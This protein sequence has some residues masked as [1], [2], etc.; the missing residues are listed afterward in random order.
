MSSQIK[1]IETF[2]RSELIQIINGK[3]Q[4]LGVTFNAEDKK[5]FFGIYDL[6]STKFRFVGGDISI[7]TQVVAFVKE[8]ATD[9]SA[10]YFLQQNQRKIMAPDTQQLS[11][12]LFFA[13]KE[14]TLDVVVSQLG[15]RTVN[16]EDMRMELFNNK[17]KPLLETAASSVKLVR[18][19][20]ENIVKIIKVGDKVR[21][22]VVCVFCS[23]EKERTVII[24]CN[25][26]ANSTVCYW[27]TSNFKQHLA[28]HTKLKSTDGV[29]LSEKSGAN[30]SFG[31]EDNMTDVEILLM[32]ANQAD[33]KK[34]KKTMHTR[35]ATR[36]LKNPTK[37]K[38]DS[39]Q[40]QMEEDKDDEKKPCHDSR[41]TSDM[42]TLVNQMSAQN[43]KNITSARTHS[44]Q[45]EVMKFRLD[46]NE[47]TV[48]VV[49]IKPNGSC[50]FGSIAHQLYGCQVDSQEHQRKT[51][52]LRDET[53]SYIKSNYERFK[54]NLQGRVY[55][56]SE[57]MYSA[58]D[59]EKE[60]RFF[61][62]VCLPRSVCFAGHESVKAISE[63][64]KINIMTISENGECYMA[65]DFNEE[66]ERTVFLALR[67][68]NCDKASGTTTNAHNSQRNHYD[69][70]SKIDHKVLYALAGNCIKKNVAKQL[71]N[72]SIVSLN[73][74]LG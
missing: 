10:S 20:G 53:V 2:A 32:L 73:S 3:C 5:Y 4:Q 44:E 67:L 13:R 25:A 74:T 51:Q 40:L 34:A 59:L 63:I 41:A 47:E 38:I 56:R 37:T 28:R 17:L 36:Q 39:K 65:V 6:D 43:L 61:L 58:D 49:N 54:F 64:E 62:N 22:D 1:D 48:E 7:I 69:S 21:A 24:Q 11:I 14:K 9:G 42:E 72:N 66:Y 29:K 30:E 70:V 26:A 15:V 60:C 52:V 71:N 16:E 8:K 19:I 33:L 31:D 18:P 35:L 27:N 57:Q 55:E 45:C 46:S 50:F 12:G 23:G 68:T